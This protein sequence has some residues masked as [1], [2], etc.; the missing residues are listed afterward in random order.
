MAF[1]ASQT[2]IFIKRHKKGP[3]GR[4]DAGLSFCDSFKMAP[5]KLTFENVTEYF[6]KTPL[7]TPMGKSH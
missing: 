2:L 6:I 3:S 7:I 4:M 1:S 5:E